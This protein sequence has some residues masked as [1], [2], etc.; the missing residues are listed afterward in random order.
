MK[1]F[2][3]NK[4]EAGQRLDKYLKKLL[5]AAPS[6][7]LYKMLRK[8]N[9]TLNGKKS[10]GCE[11]IVLGDTVE[12]FFSPETFLK[13]ASPQ[14]SISH[15]TLKKQ[16]PN[17]S[18]SIIYEDADIIVINKPVGMLSQKASQN[19]VSANEYIIGYLLNS[20]Q[21]VPED[22]ATFHPSVCNRL[23][24]NTS[25]LLIA[26]KSMKG[27]QEMSEEL[28]SR[29]IEKY[30]RCLVKGKITDTQTIEGWLYKDEKQNKVSITQEERL[31]SKYIQTKYSP[32]HQYN[33]YTL[34]EVHL[35]TGR[36][37]QIRAHL[38]SI[39]HPIIGDSKYGD[40]QTNLQFA[41]TCNLHSQLL[42]A[43]R[44]KLSNGRELIAPLPAEFV[45]ALQV[46]N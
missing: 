22:F 28:K 7:F 42:H 17:S 41:K 9:I 45:G 4:N 18:L 29:T 26:G 15:N 38:S 25:G 13:F 30:Y 2:Q 35:I 24:R 6:S 36:S 44:M 3:I 31:D 8:K 27:L 5:P 33:Q 10:D 20:G 14:S 21:I 19:D 37:H 39:D 16:Y 23:D 11:K 12:L 1:S 43:Y 46:I 32:I 40:K 34:L